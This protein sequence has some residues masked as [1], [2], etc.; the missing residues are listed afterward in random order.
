MN[1]PKSFVSVARK[2]GIEKDAII[3]AVTADF[4]MDYR[5]SDSIVAL[6]KDKLLLATYPFMEKAEH[7]FGGYSSFQIKED[8]VLAEE[9]ALQDF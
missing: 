9:P 6:T 5:F 8:L 3:F 1:L 7:G 2:Y 4:D